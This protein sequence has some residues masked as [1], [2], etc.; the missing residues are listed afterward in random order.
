MKLKRNDIILIIVV[1]IIGIVA[2]LYFFLNKKTSGK[3]VLKY[4]NNLSMDIDLSKDREI[5]L[6]SNGIKIHL[7]IKDGA[8]AF[9]HSECPDH[10]CEQFGYIKNVGDSAVCLPARA[11]VTIVK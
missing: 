4:G 6:E 1:L 8:I 10:I 9:I 3:A 5:D 7:N 2:G 11:S